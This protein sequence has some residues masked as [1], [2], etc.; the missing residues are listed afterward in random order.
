M[1]PTSSRYGPRRYGY[2]RCRSYAGGR[3]PCRGVRASVREVTSYVHQ[4]LSDAPTSDCSE[5]AERQAFFEAWSA[6]SPSAQ[7]D[8]LPKVVERIELDV[9]GGRMRL[10]VA[11]AA[12]EAVKRAQ[13][14]QDLPARRAIP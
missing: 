11:D 8:L 6:L 1:S 12:L 10:D 3:P 2:Y 5:F 9:P 7:H 14:S 4:A 13:G